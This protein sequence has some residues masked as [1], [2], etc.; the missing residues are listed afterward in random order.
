MPT[1]SSLCAREKLN[2]FTGS[3]KS[4]KSLETTAMTMHTVETMTV[5]MIISQ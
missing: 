4:G 3:W 5:R 2:T 1:L